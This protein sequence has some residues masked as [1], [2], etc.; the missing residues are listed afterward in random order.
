MASVVANKLCLIGHSN[1]RCMRGVRHDELVLF[2]PEVPRRVCVIQ[3]TFATR[4]LLVGG[5][6]RSALYTQ[7]QVRLAFYW[8]IN[9][10]IEYNNI[11]II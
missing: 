5:I 7:P 3:G 6:C 10:I 11:I 2:V 9:G 8:N 1:V 4:H